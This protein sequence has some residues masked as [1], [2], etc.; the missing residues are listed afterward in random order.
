MKDVKPKFLFLFASVKY[1]PD[2][3]ILYLHVKKQSV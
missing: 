1:A 3:L 2:F